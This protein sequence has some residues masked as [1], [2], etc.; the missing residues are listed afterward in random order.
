MKLDAILE[1]DNNSRIVVT[2][3][4]QWD[5]EPQTKIL[6]DEGQSDEEAI[7]AVHKLVGGRNHRITRK[8]VK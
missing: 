1:V 7:R 2:Y 6:Y 4:V 8:N 5:D 3:D